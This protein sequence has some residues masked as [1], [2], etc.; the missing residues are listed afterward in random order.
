MPDFPKPTGPYPVGASSLSLTDHDR[1]AHLLNDDPGRGLLLKLWYPAENPVGAPET[2]WADLR[3]TPDLPLPFRALLTYLRS[4]KSESYRE[5]P[6]AIQAARSGL[7][8][9]NHGLIS[10]AEENTALMEDLASHGHIVLAL[11]HLDQMSELQALNREQ[12][13]EKRKTDRAFHTRLMAATPEERAAMGRPY[14]EAADNTN[15]IVGARTADILFALKHLDDICAK[16]P[17]LSADKLTEG[18]IGLA[19]FSVGGAVA[20]E[21]SRLNT[22]VKAIA[23]IDGGLFG[24]DI[25]HTIRPAYLMLY[26]AISQGINDALLPPQARCVTPV[27]TKHL[28]Y[29]DLSMLL[30]ILRVLG[31]TGKANARQIVKQRNSAVR[32]FFAEQL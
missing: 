22:Q 18:A 5:A 30:P 10:F 3:K 17:A 20:S 24:A 32:E 9:Y 16:V 2:L 28:N 25:G 19:G 15:R 26:S 4:V 13:P 11:Q 27:S 1:P 12:T 29:H 14:Y 31:A 21:F 6:C 23:N 7:I 8:I